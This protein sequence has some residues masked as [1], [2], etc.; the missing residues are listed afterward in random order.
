MPALFASV[1]INLA[2]SLNSNASLMFNG[3]DSRAVLDGSFLDGGEQSDY[4]FNLWIKPTTLGQN[5]TLLGKSEYWKEWGIVLEADGGLR[6]GGAWPYYYWGSPTASGSVTVGTWQNI[7]VAVNDGSAYFYVNGTLVGL[8]AVQNPL[9]F[10]GST[11][12]GP[13]LDATMSIGHA[14]SATTPDYH[15]YNGLIYGITVW[16]RTLSADEILAL[17]TTGVPLTTDGLQNRVMLDEG[18]G[19][20]IH[21]SVSALTGRNLS[22]QWS[23]D[24]PT[25]ASVPEGSPSWFGGLTVAG[26]LGVG[27]S[28]RRRSLK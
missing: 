26:I 2:V 14:D 3:A 16:D 4:T 12:G 10:F 5:S 8:E 21:D 22:A 1:A 17:A 25:F 24:A 28:I 9:S 27:A 20:V 6:L 7:G 15:F 19:T 11:V 23:S 13:L 18:S